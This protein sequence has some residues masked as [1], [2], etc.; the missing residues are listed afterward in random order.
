MIFLH[1]MLF[2]S[3]NGITATEKVTRQNSSFFSEISRVLQEQLSIPR[4]AA[5]NPSFCTAVQDLIKH[6]LQAP[7]SMH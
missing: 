6:G 3:S 5:G 7:P 1:G 2:C 4:V